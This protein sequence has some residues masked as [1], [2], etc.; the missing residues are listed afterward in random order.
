MKAS[1]FIVEMIRRQVFEV[2][3]SVQGYKFDLAR[4]GREISITRALHQ[5]DNK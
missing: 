4:K 3:N 1:K 5:D 2:G